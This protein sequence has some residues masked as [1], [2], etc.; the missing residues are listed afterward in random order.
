[1]CV[2]IRYKF[3][4]IPKQFETIRNNSKRTCTE[5]A[6]ESRRLAAALRSV[7][8]RRVRCWNSKQFKTIRIEAIRNNSKQFEAHLRSA[9][10]GV[11]PPLLTY[12]DAKRCES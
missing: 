11:A 2:G 9:E 8:S 10:P 4:T 3:E 7:V 1:V 5:P 6:R 12:S